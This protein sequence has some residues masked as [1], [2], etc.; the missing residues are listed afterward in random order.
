MVEVRLQQRISKQGKNRYVTY[1]VTLPKVIVEAVPG[2]AKAKKFEVEVD[3][4]KIVLKP[5][6]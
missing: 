5:R 1:V 4:G 6:K 2:L 3:S